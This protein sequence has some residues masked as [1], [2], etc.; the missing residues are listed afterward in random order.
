MCQTIVVAFTFPEY[1]G[2]AFMQATAFIYIGLSLSLVILIWIS[3]R[4]NVQ[5]MKLAFEDEMLLYTSTPTLDQR[6][7]EGCILE[8]KF[9]EKAITSQS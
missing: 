4:R 8:V 1:R 5:N 6:R 3:E 7:Y 2:Q 9:Q